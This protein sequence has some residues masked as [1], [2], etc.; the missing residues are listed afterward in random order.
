MTSFV[1]QRT[2]IKVKIDKPY[3]WSTSLGTV[4]VFSYFLATEH[5]KAARIQTICKFPHPACKYGWFYTDLEPN[6][7]QPEVLQD[8]KFAS[9][10]TLFYKQHLLH[11][12]LF[13]NTFIS[14]TSLK[15]AYSET[16]SWKISSKTIAK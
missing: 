9:K 5:H 4:Y 11:V 1:R 13:Y 8:L 7:C 15:M 6:Y 3:F 2:E 12:F 16:K 14:S 10:Y